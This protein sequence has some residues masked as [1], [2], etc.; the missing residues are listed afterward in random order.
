[1]VIAAM[2]FVWNSVC[3]NF[4]YSLMD[5]YDHNTLKLLHDIKRC[6]FPLIRLN[7]YIIFKYSRVVPSQ[8]SPF[9]CH[10]V[11]RCMCECFCVYFKRLTNSDNLNGI[12]IS[13]HLSILCSCNYIGFARRIS[14]IVNKCCFAKVISARYWMI[15]FPRICWCRK[16][17]HIIH[18]P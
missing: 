10:S 3:S 5:F 11:I 12:Y 1:M 6:F 2:D 9:Y 17:F 18:G 13:E 16:V 7:V 8:F 4:W 14:H 15:I